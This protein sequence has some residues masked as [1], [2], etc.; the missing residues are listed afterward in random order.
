[1][2]DGRSSGGADGVAPAP[3]LISNGFT[4]DLFP[5]DENLRYANLLHQRFPT[6]PID[7]VDMDFGH[8][9]GQNKAADAQYLYDRTTAWIDRFVMHANDVTAGPSAGPAVVVRTQTCP[10]TAPSVQYSAASW[11]AIHPG[12]LRFTS[13]A[14][15]TVLSTGGNPNN[16]K[17]FDPIG[18]GGAC[19]TVPDDNE[20]GAALYTL[21][22]A[23][24][25]GYTMLGSP[26]ITARLAVTGSYPELVSRLVDVAPDGSRTLVDRGIY[27]PDAAGQQ[28][29]QLHPGAWHF[30]AGHRPELE[31]LGQDAPY[32]RKSNGQF[33]I[34]VSQLALVLPTHET[35]GNQITPAAPLPR[36][37]GSTP[38]PGVKT[39]TK[40]GP[41]GGGSAPVGSGSG[42][43]SAKVRPRFAGL[44]LRARQPRHRGRITLRAS[45][46]LA[47]TRGRRCSGRVDG[48]RALRRPHHVPA[49]RRPVAALPLF[50][51]PALR[52]AS[53]R[54]SL[55]QPRAASPA[56]RGAL[57]RRQRRTAPRPHR[58]RDRR[59]PP[60]TQVSGAPRLN[61]P[62]ATT[63]RRT[64]R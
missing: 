21:P 20:P 17:T 8:Q 28:V 23:T 15:Q 27:R 32:A 2:L 57:L 12:Q 59:A 62:R 10:S 44:T 31:L 13:A 48:H 56:P 64:C 11:P 30:A 61:R 25:A 40:G 18:G 35:S 19:A 1:M 52:R 54:P 16:A 49:T 37:V 50:R 14:A 29:F 63:A 43:L 38:A 7:L 60:L 9:R 6:T 55:P 53:P 33:S 41:F 5:V 45:G 39:T 42:T 46:R 22:A 47:H 26:T 4:D 51:E 3:V 34:A 36:P 24:G 58:A